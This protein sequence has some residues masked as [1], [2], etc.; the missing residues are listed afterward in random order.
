MTYKQIQ[1]EYKKLYFKTIKSCW[2]AD[3]KRELGFTVRVAYN[4]INIDSI[5][6]TCNN[7]NIRENIKSIIGKPSA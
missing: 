1:E 6:N 4:R 3:V 2:I 7:L 5:K